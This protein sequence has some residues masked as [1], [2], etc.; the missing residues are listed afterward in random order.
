MAGL[1]H[2]KIGRFMRSMHYRERL[3]LSGPLGLRL[4]LGELTTWQSLGKTLWIRE[5]NLRSV[6]VPYVFSIYKHQALG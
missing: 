4:W 1:T 6:E 3:P 2:A 5:F